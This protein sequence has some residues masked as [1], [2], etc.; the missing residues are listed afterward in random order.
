MTK[1]DLQARVP[2][3]GNLHEMRDRLRTECGLDAFAQPAEVWLEMSVAAAARGE[4]QYARD[5]EQAMELSNL[6]WVTP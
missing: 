3:P 5:C 4:A 6:R 1:Q 2:H